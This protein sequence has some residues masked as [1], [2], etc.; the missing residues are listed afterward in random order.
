M[1][2]NNHLAILKNGSE[3]WNHWRNKNISVKPNL[4]GANL[5]GAN[6]KGA[7]LKEAN[8]KGANLSHTDIRGADFTNGSLEDANFSNATAGLQKRWAV[9]LV[10]ILWIIAGISGFLSGFIG[11][12]LFF[13]SGSSSPHN[14]VVGLTALIVIIFLGIVIIRKGLNT[15]GA[16]AIA[17]AIAIAVAGVGV[18]TF[19]ITGNVAVAVAFAIPVA[20]A[21]VGIFIFIFLVAIAIAGAIAVAGAV[22][23]AVAIAVAGVGAVAFVVVGVGARVRSFTF[24]FT[25]TASVAIA[26]AVI[27]F[28]GYIAWRAMKKDEKYSLIRNI[29]IAFTAIGGTSF[30]KANLTDADFMEATLTNTDFREAVLTRTYFYKTKK[31][32]YV[33]PGSTYLQDKEMCQLLVTGNGS[34]KNFN[35]RNLQGLNFSKANFSNAS[36]I[37]SN[38]YQSSLKEANLEGTLL[39]RSQ[40]ESTDLRETLLTGACIEDWIVS[41][42]TN[43]YGVKCKYVFMKLNK[44]DKC[45]QMPPIGEFKNDD[46]IIFVQSIVDT[47][48]LYHKRDVNPKLA[49]YVLQSLSKEYQCTLE[50]VKFE[51]KGDS[52]AILEVRIP[53]NINEEQIKETYYD[54]YQESFNLYMTDPK[55]ELKPST[56]IKN[57]TVHRGVV[58]DGN[59]SN[60]TIYNPGDIE[61]SESYQSKY[62]QRNSNNQFVDTAKPGSQ[63]I[64]TQNNNYTPEQKQ[65]LAE[66]AVE[67]QKLLYQLT[68]NNQTNDEQVTEAIHDEIKNNP[69]LKARLQSALQAGGLEAL[70]AI[71]NHPLFNIPAETI[72]GFIEAE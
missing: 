12:L 56:N 44:N 40:F 2:D 55:K 50:I 42:T 5:K 22:A 48:K 35:N 68:Q 69:T 26:V 33:R 67:I 60:S 47:I 13:I 51:K 18:F 17:I 7:N 19:T 28:S 10:C 16:G 59:V 70:K 58:I 14:Q 6:L 38:F 21:A 29:A 63:V 45:D 23:G 43:L 62:D 24:I 53:G 37:G 3:F 54:K 1:E 72:K 57:I 49:L 71:F 32:D 41:K 61:M 8:L 65:T 25:F 20:A 34:G 36:F 15:A 11:I 27:L 9:F 30:R 46:F 64:F 52:G 66:A 4:E 31:I 39:V